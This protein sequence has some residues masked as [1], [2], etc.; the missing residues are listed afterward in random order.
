MFDH[1][2]STTTPIQIHATSFFDSLV[3]ARP[4]GNAASSASGSFARAISTSSRAVPFLHHTVLHPA[5]VK[6]AFDSV[7]DAAAAAKQDETLDW[8]EASTMQAHPESP[9]APLCE[10]LEDGVLSA[11]DRCWSTCQGQCPQN[12]LKQG[13]IYCASIYWYLLGLSAC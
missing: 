6:T 7:E 1:G 2:G 9:V 12:V 8:K 10:D 5:V 4:A 13:I 3:A 11:G